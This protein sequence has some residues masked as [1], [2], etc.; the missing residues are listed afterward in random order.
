MLTNY[1][2]YQSKFSATFSTLND[3]LMNSRNKLTKINDTTKSMLVAALLEDFG[4]QELG[5]D[6]TND[7]DLSNITKEMHDFIYFNNS[8][9][10]DFKTA[11]TNCLFKQYEELIDEIMEAVIDYRMMRE[12]NNHRRDEYDDY[13][14][15]AFYFY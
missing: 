1:S 10:K 13:D 2:E 4:H 11:L 15:N 8:N 5:H 3:F 12:E 14:F 6:Y 7:L 9:E